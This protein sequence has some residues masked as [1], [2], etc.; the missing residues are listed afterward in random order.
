MKKFN[1]DKIAKEPEETLEIREAKKF[2]RSG[3][4]D[5]MFPKCFKLLAKGTKIKILT[6]DYFLM[7]E[8]V[9]VMDGITEK[10]VCNEIAPSVFIT[11]KQV[12]LE[13]KGYTFSNFCRA[14]TKVARYISVYNP[15]KT[16]MILAHLDTIC[17]WERAGY[18]Y[19][20]IVNASNF[21]RQQSTGKTANWADP[22]ILDQA[23]RLH[24][25]TNRTP[26]AYLTDRPIAEP[27][28][29]RPNPTNA[30]FPE[31]SFQFTE[32]QPLMRNDFQTVEKST[33]GV[34]RQCKF[35]LQ[36]APCVYFNR[37]KCRF[38]HIRK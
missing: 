10:S 28:R 35:F 6:L 2:L 19:D 21:V 15:D 20:N 23:F 14:L 5:E 13:K 38:S 30:S 32:R 33:E 29:T 3:K 27:F 9:A 34:Q 17:E 36:G 18:T 8:V 37:G 16:A 12:N 31:S 7:I 25:A 24:V 22:T 26:M 1:N 4:M 11:S